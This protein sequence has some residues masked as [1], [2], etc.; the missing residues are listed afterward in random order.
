[1]TDLPRDPMLLSVVGIASSPFAA[2]S[3][4]QGGTTQTTER[5]DVFGITGWELGE[6]DWAIHRSSAQRCQTPFFNGII[7][8]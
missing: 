5:A 4:A 2:N 1:M 3:G 8:K 6:C 7:R